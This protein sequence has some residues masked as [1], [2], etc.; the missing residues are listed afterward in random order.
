V[1]VDL[2]DWSG[3]ALDGTAL[4]GSLDLARFG[5]SYLNL[6]IEDQ[7]TGDAVVAFGYLSSL[8][9]AP[10]AAV[11]EPSTV[12]LLFVGMAGLLARRKFARRQAA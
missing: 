6:R 1:D 10:A 8:Q 11:P 12:S 5:Y 9:S 2:N 4:P 7:S 3:T